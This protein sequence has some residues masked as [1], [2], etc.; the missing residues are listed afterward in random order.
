M[1]QRILWWVVLCGLAGFAALA[2]RG[3]AQTEP[4]SAPF[5]CPNVVGS[6]IQLSP[7]KHYLLPY[8]KPATFL[9]GQSYEYL[10]HIPQ[11]ERKSTYC[12]FDPTSTSTGPSANYKDRF[13]AMQQHK[14]NVIRIETMFNHSP[15]WETKCNNP[16]A[17][18][19][20]TLCFESGSP[21]CGEVFVDE[22]PFR[23]VCE[24]NA[25][26]HC[27]RK[28]DITNRDAAGKIQLNKNYLDHLDQVVCDAYSKNIVVEVSLFNVWD[29]HWETSPFNPVNSVSGKTQGFTA[30]KYF[31]SFSAAGQQDTPANLDARLA[32]RAA[33]EAVI[34]RLQKYPNVI[35][36]VANEPDFIPDPS[37]TPAEVV[38][39]QQ[40]V[41]GLIVQ[42]DQ[43][44]PA[45][46]QPK[47]A[48]LIEIEGHT[49]AT[50]I[51]PP[52]RFA[53]AS[54]EAAH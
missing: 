48:H 14:N 51:A 42:N 45:H 19:P 43:T 30:Q 49:D 31:M 10:C 50:I 40:W 17:N 2:Q 52:A 46:P 33:V 47:A 37:P 15:G 39:W 23:Y 21:C 35:W 44:D 5:S 8:G 6:P 53:R 36:E 16:N 38:T 27:K 20:V 7:S 34:H 26:G 11:P 24:N 18:P 12:T 22:Q 41:I 9:G 3:S 1:S 28:W 4:V 13:S 54:V 25:S 32:Q 29:G